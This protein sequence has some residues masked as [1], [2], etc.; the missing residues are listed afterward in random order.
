MAGATTASG[1]RSRSFSRKSSTTRSTPCGGSTSPSPRLQRRTT[2][3]GRCLPRSASRSRPEDSIAKLALIN[4]E[5]KRRKTVAKFAARR[6]ALLATINDVK[7]SDEDRQEAREQ[8]LR[9]AV[10]L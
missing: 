6:A 2:R 9:S 8:A 1:S 3:R 10:A 4:R 5:Q 7:R